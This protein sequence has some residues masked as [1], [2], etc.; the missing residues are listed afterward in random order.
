[1]TATLDNTTYKLLN[2]LGE[3]QAY[4]YICTRRLLHG[5]PIP[6]GDVV[7]EI[8]EV[9]SMGQA[10]YTDPVE[11]DTMLYTGMYARWPRHLIQTTELEEGTTADEADTSANAVAEEGTSDVASSVEVITTAD[12]ADTSANAVAIG[13][14]TSAPDVASSIEEDTL[15]RAHGKCTVVLHDVYACLAWLGLGLSC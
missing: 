2:E 10:L 6:E 11:G 15:T 1:M 8:Y 4:G 14:C 7:M 9:E 12:E 13:K 3:V 5:H